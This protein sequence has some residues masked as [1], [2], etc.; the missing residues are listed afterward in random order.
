M[1]A[2]RRSLPVKSGVSFSG[3][4]NSRRG[5]AALT[6]LAVCLLL[7]AV[8]LS[9]ACLVRD[10]W[11]AGQAALRQEQL[12]N[13][14]DSL[15]LR[16]L[17]RE[18][19]ETLTPLDLTPGLL[20]PGNRSVRVFT[21]IQRYAPLGLRFLKVCTEDSDGRSFTRQQIQVRW[22]DR[23]RR[24]AAAAPLT[25]RDAVPDGEALAK[26]GVLY[27]STCGAAFP[28]FGTYPIRNWIEG[29][30]VSSDNIT[31][32][33]IP[34]RRIYQMRGEYTAKGYGTL[35]G[36]GMLL[37]P[38]FGTFEDQIEIPDRV[39]IL[40][41]RGLWIG[42]N[43]RFADAL[44]LCNGT[45]HLGEGCEIHGAVFA[46]RIALHGGSVRIVGS[47]EA[48]RPFETVICRRC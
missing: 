39:I 6:L 36:T 40:A 17:E 27:A 21:S 28:E 43:V 33:G 4:G 22:T 23:L 3:A 29:G 9:L 11:V 20:Y 12:E 25:V 18:K 34:M 15:M 8:P 41:D 48:L 47:P 1:A 19:T 5:F 45:L 26:N 10:E 35:V 46:E 30:F 42:R 37:F 14:T 31:R 13:I 2:S 32:D 24:L 38:K 16:E 44:I 7:S